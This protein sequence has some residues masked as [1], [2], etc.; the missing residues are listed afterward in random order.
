MAKSEKASQA[1]E[2]DNSAMFGL[3]SVLGSAGLRWS[4]F[5]IFHTNY[6][7][8][9]FR[10]K[11]G[12]SEQNKN[13]GAAGG[14]FGSMISSGLSGDASV[15]AKVGAALNP[16]AAAAPSAKVPQVAVQEKPHDIH[17]Q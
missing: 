10:V 9:A 11:H 13:A 17:L 16:A 8:T 12:C 2:G 4:L 7:S 1:L 6:E 15:L 5:H 14:A 3:I